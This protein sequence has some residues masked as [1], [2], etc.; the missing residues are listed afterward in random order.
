[1]GK[2][3]VGQVVSQCQELCEDVNFG[4]AR[5]WKGGKEGLKAI[6]F[7]PVYA[8][9]EIIHAAG[10]LPVG[11]SGGSAETEAERL[12]NRVGPGCRLPDSGIE[13][14]M[15][16]KIDFLDGMI[17][18]AHCDA[19]RGLS[20]SWQLLFANKYVCCLGVPQSC[21]HDDGG[22]IFSDGLQQLKAGLEELGGRKITDD[23][24]NH[25]IAVYNENRRWVNKVYD[26]RAE[27]PWKAP[28]VEVYL[29]MRAGMVL[30]VEDHTLLIQEYLAAAEAE[31]RPRRDHCRVALTGV[32]CEHPP[33]TLIRSLET[34]GAYIVDDDFMPVNRWV[35]EEI[36]PSGD[37]VDTLATAFLRQAARSEAGGDSYRKGDDFLELV[38]KRRADG[39][40]FATPGCCEW[41]RH[42]QP[43]LTS[44]LAAC[45]IPYITMEYAGESGKAQP[46]RVRGNGPLKSIVR[47]LGRARSENREQALASAGIEP[48]A[49]REETAGSK[50]E[51]VEAS[52]ESAAT[53]RPRAPFLAARTGGDSA[54]GGGPGSR[55]S[56]SA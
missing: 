9:R 20:D 37:P 10:M 18:T 43:M 47:N 48:A 50:A 40:V 13:R 29:L 30:Q 6:G 54:A 25:S 42:D 36:D 19:L 33:L 53:A 56:R 51:A 23:D 32:F 28:T 34:A 17:F 27:K 49:S 8:P 14:A 24:L 31:E 44:R 3:T 4:S 21:M 46:I 2:R 22:S 11:I 52:T 16:G 41:A 55:F 5:A 45:R 39:V 38:A 35:Q 15:T 12:A 1:M 26:Y 7:L